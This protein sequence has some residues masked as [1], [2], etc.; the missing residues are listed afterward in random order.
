VIRLTYSSPTLYQD[1][2]RYESKILATV[3]LKDGKVQIEGDER[4]FDISVPVVEPETGRQLTY[5][6][7]GELW[8]KNL[9]NAYR[10]GDINVSVAFPVKQDEFEVNPN[11]VRSWTDRGVMAAI[12]VPHPSQ[13]QAKA[14]QARKGYFA[15]LP[16]SKP[17]ESG[18]EDELLP[19]ED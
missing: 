8:A 19:F 15:G 9:P 17:F 6:N 4:Y 1:P 18:G 10:A 2:L 14:K 5:E 11:K 7:D 16:L 13:I 12:E 3:I